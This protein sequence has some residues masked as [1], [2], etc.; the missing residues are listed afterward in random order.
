MRK[1]CSSSRPDFLN[2]FAS[3]SRCCWGK[4][5]VWISGCTSSCEPLE[6]IAEGATRL[7]ALLPKLQQTFPDLAPHLLAA[8]VPVQEDTNAPVIAEFCRTFR[9]RM[10]QP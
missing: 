9:E 3:R 10:A 8:V 7:A 2:V 4:G 6:P 1:R 5:V